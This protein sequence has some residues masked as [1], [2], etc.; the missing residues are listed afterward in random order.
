MKK[1]RALAQ[2]EDFFQ[3]FLLS[4][5]FVK[6]DDLVLLLDHALCFPSTCQFRRNSQKGK[7]MLSDMSHIKLRFFT[8]FWQL[9]Y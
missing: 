6:A 1:N 7:H 5:T 2:V 3:T 9:V 8:Q 4:L